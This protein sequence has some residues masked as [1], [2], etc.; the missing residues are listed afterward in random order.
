[1]SMINSQGYIAIILYLLGAALYVVMLED[2]ETG[3][4]NL[5]ST[6]AGLL[7][8]YGALVVIYAYLR[9]ELDEDQ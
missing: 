3:E 7:W 8:P 9:G 5:G 2:A 6:I 1:M 4:S